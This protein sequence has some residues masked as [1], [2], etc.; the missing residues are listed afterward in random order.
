[1]ILETSRLYIRNLSET[2][3]QEM[4]N[5]FIDFNNS[6]YAV[7]DMP[8]PTEDE[9]TR[10]LTKR[11]AE[12]KLFFVVFLKELSDMLGYVCFHKDGDKY[13]LGYC[14]HSAYHSKGYA[15]ESTKAL[16]EYFVTEC[17]ATGFTAGTAINNIPS[18]RLLE[19]LGFICASTEMVSFDNIYSFQGG[20]FVL[21]VK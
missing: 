14:F 19:K 4:K 16:I 6:Q 9:E 2:D 7:Y 21:S 12:S 18:C 5:I 3:W 1:M 20:N 17:G 15:Y 10:A 13:D 8:L 11:F